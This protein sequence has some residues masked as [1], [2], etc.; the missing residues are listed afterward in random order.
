LAALLLI[1]LAALYWKICVLMAATGRVSPFGSENLYVLYYPLIRYGVESMKALHIPLWNPYQSL[2]AP[3]LGSALFGLFS[4]FSFLYYILPTHIAMGWSTVLNIALAGFFTFLFLNKSLKIAPAGALAGAIVFMFSGPL[5]LE[6]IHPS[7]VG[8][9]SFLPLLLYLTQKIF[10]RESTRWAALF[11]VIL[12][13]QMLTGAVQVIV[14]SI[15][16]TGAYAMALFYHAWRDKRAG[17]RPLVLIV[18]GGLVAIALSLIQWLPLLELSGHTGRDASGLSL[19][20]AEPFISV[21][22][23][24]FVIKSLLFGGRGMTIGLIPVLLGLFAVFN[25]RSRGRT[26]FFAFMALLT[27]LMAFGTH[28]PLYG[29]Y[30]HY[31]PT[32][33]MFRVPV[34]W[35]WLTAFSVAVLAAYGAGAIFREL[36]ARRGLRAAALIIIPFLI[37]VF[38]FQKNVMRLYNHPQQTPALFTRH[39]E[40][41]AFLRKVQ[42][43]YRTYISSDFGRDFSLL[44]KFGTIEKVYVLNDYESL[45]LGSYQRFAAA[46]LGRDDMLSKKIFYGAFMLKNGQ[47]SLRLMSLL[48]TGFVMEK[49]H[50]PFGKKTPPGMDEIYN[51]KGVK[52]YRYKGALPRAYVV[53]RSE[54]IKDETTALKRLAS[55]AFNPRAAA[56]LEHDAGLAKAPPQGPAL[57]RARI[58]RLLPEKVEIRADLR[59]RGVL[60]MTD[61]FYPGWRAYVD[62]AEAPILRANT[63]MRGLVLDKGPHKV[64]FVYRPL[65]FRIGLWVSILTLAG[66]L[67]YLGLDIKKG[68]RKRP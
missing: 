3:F 28:T 52:I 25:R 27:L 13:C 18:I 1:G 5:L 39:A 44:Q 21:F 4:P 24:A 22:T 16:L 6:I 54:T 62:G 40:E 56:I 57:T 43:T 23:P 38:L 61:F 45:S 41:G 9:M 2:G 7:L 58:T 60:V 63:I 53:Y 29:I 35:L 37:T 42:G 68:A 50:G 67:I 34:R 19:K 49:G 66:L 36:E 46:V 65:P 17:M 55:P 33:K 32:G 14:H 31:I 48:S 47:K 12:A 20:D 51:K 8:A 26:L 15:F 59:E 10:E 30:Y 64:V 11:A